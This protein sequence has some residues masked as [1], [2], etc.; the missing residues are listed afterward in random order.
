MK[1]RDLIMKL[2]NGGFR[3]K[4]HGRNHD[5]YE[6]DGEEENA[7]LHKEINEKLAQSILRKWGL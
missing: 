5:V 3:F 6:R 2:E 4:R 7:P 1:R